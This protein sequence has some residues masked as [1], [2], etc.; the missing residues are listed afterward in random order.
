MQ[1]QNET[2]SFIKIDKKTLIGV[3]LLLTAIMMLVGALT[4]IVTP[5]RLRY[6]TRRFNY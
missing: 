2:K 1:N 3:T 5:R 6:N 4:Q